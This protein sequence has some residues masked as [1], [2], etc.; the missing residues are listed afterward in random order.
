MI[1]A[2]QTEHSPF[3]R[4]IED[5]I[6]ATRRALGTAPGGLQQVLFS[7]PEATKAIIGKSVHEVSRGIR[8][9][10]SAKRPET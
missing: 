3:S 1:C 10:A 8:L 6:L 7:Y 4:G 2:L 5:G 9:Q